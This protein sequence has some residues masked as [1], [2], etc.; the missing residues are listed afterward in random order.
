[1]NKISF[2]LIC[3]DC[4][5]MFNYSDLIETDKSDICPQCKGHNWSEYKEETE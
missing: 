5:L 4:G 2:E 3:E 1:M